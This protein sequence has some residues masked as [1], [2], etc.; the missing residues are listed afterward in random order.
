MNHRPEN[1]HVI[2]F[3][4]AVIE[5]VPNGQRNIFKSAERLSRIPEVPAEIGASS[6]K[7][8]TFEDQ[9]YAMDI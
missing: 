9:L 6:P 3:K 7:I 8:Y 2:Q 1:L 5:A 4:F